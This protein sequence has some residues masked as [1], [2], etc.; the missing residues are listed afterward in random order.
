VVPGD[1]EEMTAALLDRTGA[2]ERQSW[3]SPEKALGIVI[4]IRLTHA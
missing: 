1:T 4:G 2:Q 3:N